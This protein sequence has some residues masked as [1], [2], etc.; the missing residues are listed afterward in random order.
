MAVRS[1]NTKI[2]MRSWAIARPTIEP[3]NSNIKK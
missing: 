2:R 3:M 1:Q